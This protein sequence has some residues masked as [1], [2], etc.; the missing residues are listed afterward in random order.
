V[1]VYQQAL[2]WLIS[3]DERY[4]RNAAAIIDSW[5]VRNKSFHGKN[6]PLVRNQL[7]TAH[8]HNPLPLSCAHSRGYWRFYSVQRPGNPSC[9]HS[10][11]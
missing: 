9:R 3:S 2:M 1:Q 8:T 11:A 4:A 10:D 5:S 6:A 7:S